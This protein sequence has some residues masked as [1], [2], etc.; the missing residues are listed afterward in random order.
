MH[1]Y[2]TIK[3]I[4]YLFGPWRKAAIWNRCMRVILAIG[5][6][7]LIIWGISTITMGRLSQYV[8]GVFAALWMVTVA[9]V[10]YYR[11]RGKPTHIVRTPH[12][13]KYIRSVRKSTGLDPELKWEF[14]PISRVPSLFISMTDAAESLNCF[15]CHRGFFWFAYYTA[16]LHNRKGG[17]IIGLSNISQQTAKNMFL[18][19]TQKMW[20]KIIEAHYT[21]LIEMLWGKRLIMEYYLNIIEFG[22]GIFGCQAGCKHYFGHGIE[23]ITEQEAALLLASLPSPRKHNPH[24]MTDKFIGFRNEIWRHY[25]TNPP[26]DLN[27]RCKVYSPKQERIMRWSLVQF[28]MAVIGN[29]LIILFNRLYGKEKREYPKN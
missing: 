19:F 5:A 24:T 17:T 26:T 4:F 27:H 28:L 7:Q 15:M 16:Y 13:R 22:E 6:I 23:D 10:L 21:L 25:T 20:R 14:V 3:Q 8:L 29:E 18:P 12:V 11:F 1:L 2:P 9:Q